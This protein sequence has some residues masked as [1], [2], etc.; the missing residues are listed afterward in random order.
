[1]WLCSLLSYCGQSFR[2]PSAQHRGQLADAMQRCSTLLSLVQSCV[3]LW[4]V[5]HPLSVPLGC[6]ALAQSIQHDIRPAWTGKKE[7]Y[8]G[9][10]HGVEDLVDKSKVDIVVQR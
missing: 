6:S 7:R 2:T 3:C 10:E 8:S 1:M 5:L 9:V 4:E